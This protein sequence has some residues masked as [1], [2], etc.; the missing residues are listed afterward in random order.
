MNNTVIIHKRVEGEIKYNDGEFAEVQTNGIEGIEKNI[1]MGTIQIDRHDTNNS[2]DEFRER[3]PVGM[4]LDIIATTEINVQSW[5]EGNVTATDVNN[6][7][8][9]NES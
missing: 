8:R 1:L 2:P 3:F 6:R 9:K 5:I 7:E 4:W